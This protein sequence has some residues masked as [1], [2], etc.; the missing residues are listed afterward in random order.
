[1]LTSKEE[2]CLGTS[3]GDVTFL[4]FRTQNANAVIPWY[5]LA[6]LQP[7][8]PSPSIARASTHHIPTSSQQPAVPTKHFSS[9]RAAEVRA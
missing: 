4:V 9:M 7:Q 6:R 1:M 8:A 2:A 5:Y 3:V